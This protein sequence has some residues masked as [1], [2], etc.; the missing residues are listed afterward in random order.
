MS[1]NICVTVGI[2]NSAAELKSHA[3][4]AG[5]KKYRSVTKKRRKKHDNVV[6][7]AKTKLNATNVLIYKALVDS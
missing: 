4:T 3:L 2:A 1:F 7:L 6:L 5:I